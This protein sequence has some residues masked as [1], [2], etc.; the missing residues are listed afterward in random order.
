MA[1]SPAALNTFGRKKDCKANLGIIS[2]KDV[3][4]KKIF[5]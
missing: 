2:I 1:D 5:W 4:M 3:F